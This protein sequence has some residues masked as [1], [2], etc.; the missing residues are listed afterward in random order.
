MIKNQQN[1]YYMGIVLKISKSKG[2]QRSQ[3]GFICLLP[4]RNRYLNYFLTIC[5]L[6]TLRAR[7]IYLAAKFYPTL[8]IPSKRYI[9]TARDIHLQL[10]I[11]IFSKRYISPVRDIYLQLDIY[12]SN[13]RYISPARDTY[14]Q[15]EIY[16]S[17]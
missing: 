9:S 1:S 3:W 12:I 5:I 2:G 6:K 8:D 7:S 17:S 4:P 11:Y 14:L 10:E 16:I 15:L 13:Y